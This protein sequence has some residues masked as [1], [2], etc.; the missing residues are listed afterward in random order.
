MEEEN[1]LLLLMEDTENL[2]E[3]IM[4]SGFNSVHV[5]TLTR[6][7]E[8]KHVFEGLGMTIGYQLLDL[9]F[10][11]LSERKNSFHGDIESLT[12]TFCKL[13]FYLKVG[14]DKLT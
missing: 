12:N 7:Q 14:K 9:L 2:M 10:K 6:L 3:D 11:T 4:L 1:Q 13:E 5:E 8:L